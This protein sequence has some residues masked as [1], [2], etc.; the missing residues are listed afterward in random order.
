MEAG[1][2]GFNAVTAALLPADLLDRLLEDLPKLDPWKRVRSA[3]GFEAACV[4]VFV[5]LHKNEKCFNRYR[6]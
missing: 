6:S 3:A 4:D 5:L 2:V 1:Q